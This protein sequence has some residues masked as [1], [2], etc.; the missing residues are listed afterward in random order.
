M[1]SSALCLK[2]LAAVL[3]GDQ[4]IY[5]VIYKV[6]LWT[7]TLKIVLLLYIFGASVGLRALSFKIQLE[8]LR[9]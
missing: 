2:A 5:L 6:L 3:L 4:S 7:A 9:C 8:A 1:S